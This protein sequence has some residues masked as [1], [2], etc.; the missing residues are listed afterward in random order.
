TEETDEK[1]P[2]CGEPLIV[3]MSRFGKF[4]GCSGF[5]KCR[6]TKPIKPVVDN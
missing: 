6:F 3:R 4:L 1:C 5:P 2:E